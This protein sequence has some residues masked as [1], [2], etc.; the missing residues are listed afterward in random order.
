MVYR[1]DSVK[2]MVEGLK[3]LEEKIISC[4]KCSRL[5][6]VTP[7]PMPHIIYNKENANKLFCIGRNPGLEHSYEDVPREKFIRIYHSRWWGCKIGQYLRNILGDNFV[8]NYIFFTNI[9]KCSSP[10]NSALTKKEMENCFPF[11]ER[12]IEIVK[13]PVIVVFGKTFSDFVR[14]RLKLNIPIFYLSHPSYFM[15]NKDKTKEKEQSEKL[16][17]IRKFFLRRIL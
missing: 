5:R 9:C 15:R 8:L 14:E 1:T 7:Y 10:D 6:K 13:P 3:E 17:R 2:E 4:D 16:E 12:Q 11:L